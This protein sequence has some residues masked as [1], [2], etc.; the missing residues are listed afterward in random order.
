LTETPHR[1]V[2]S[3]Q[4]LYAFCAVDAVGIPAA[5]ELDARVESRC[6][7]CGMPLLLTL[8]RGAVTQAPPGTVVWAT[9]RDLSRPLH[10]Y[11]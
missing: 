5:L 4:P 10:T 3:G 7:G 6:H 1:L 9:E 8:T 11:T 2:L